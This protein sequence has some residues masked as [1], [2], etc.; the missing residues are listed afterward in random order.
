MDATV[1]AMAGL[2]VAALG[3]GALLL[4]AQRSPG[5]LTAMASRLPKWS[6]WIP[7]LAGLGLLASL[8]FRKPK[9]VEPPK[10]L[11]LPDTGPSKGDAV[12]GALASVAERTEAHVLHIATE[13]EVGARGAVLFGV[14][15]NGSGPD[16]PLVKAPRGRKGTGSF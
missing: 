1:V 16:K 3:L 2:V 8:F 15:P 5:T 9:V 4:W 12:D 14:K 10:V 7:I 11:I 13:D 6:P